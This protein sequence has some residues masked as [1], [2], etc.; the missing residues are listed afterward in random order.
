MVAVHAEFGQYLMNQS[1]CHHSHYCGI[2]LPAIYHHQLQETLHILLPFAT[3][4]PGT[5]SA[6]P[7][8]I[9]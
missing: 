4:G 6:G 1:W 7:S 9:N 8:H 2:G 3:T 5:E